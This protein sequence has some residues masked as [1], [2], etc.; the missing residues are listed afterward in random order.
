MATSA[1]SPG[2]GSVA[3]LALVA[4][5]GAV[6]TLT[7]AALVDALPSSAGDFPWATW[8]AN[9]T[10]AFL[11]GVVVAVVVAG[12]TTRWW[13]QPLLA[14]GLLGAFTTFA[15]L[16]LELHA[17]LEGGRAGTA[18]VYTAATLAGG[19]VAAMAG[20]RTAGAWTR[21]RREPSP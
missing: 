19:L 10:G 1:R 9:T 5:G 7:R 11:L 4:G 12:T 17:L 15:T 21:A 18:A 14:S 13:V 2:P 6:G 16:V 8:T 20:A 3:T